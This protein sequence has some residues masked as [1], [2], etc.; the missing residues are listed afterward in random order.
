MSNPGCVPSQNLIAPPAI[1]GWSEEQKRSSLDSVSTLL[2]AK[3]NIPNYQHRSRHKSETQPATVEKNQFKRS[4][5]QP[6]RRSA[7][8]SYP[9][10]SLASQERLAEQGAQQPCPIRH[11][12]CSEHPSRPPAAA[13]PRLPHPGRASPAVRGCPCCSEP[14]AA[15]TKRGGA[16]RGEQGRARP[17]PAAPPAPPG[18]AAPAR[19]Q[20]GSAR[21]RLRLGSARIMSPCRK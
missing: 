1:F 18:P 14:P 16:G 7:E 5:N 3:E 17:S 12:A 21:G 10:S 8:G 13:E 20:R 15:G 6:Q 4:P 19:R 11:R 9:G 2:S